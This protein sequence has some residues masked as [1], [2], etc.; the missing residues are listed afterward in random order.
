MEL[1]FFWNET[2]ASLFRIHPEKVR[3]FWHFFWIPGSEII[4]EQPSFIYLRVEYPTILSLQKKIHEFYKKERRGNIQWIKE[5]PKFP[6]SQAWMLHK[7]A[8]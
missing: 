6:D 1:I 8:F 3:K 7:Y 5:K 4:Q 2:C